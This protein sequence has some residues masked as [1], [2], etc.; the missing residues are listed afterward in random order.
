MVI[1][2]VHPITSLDCGKKKGDLPIKGWGSL[3]RKR[4]EARLRIKERTEGITIT[5]EKG[6]L[7]G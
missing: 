5:K 4:G 7:I 6:A 2:I 1:L 3:K